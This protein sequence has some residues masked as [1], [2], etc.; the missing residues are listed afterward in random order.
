MFVNVKANVRLIVLLGQENDNFYNGRNTFTCNRY[1]YSQ[2]CDDE[3]QREKDKTKKFRTQYA[4]PLKN[5]HRC[6]S[7][8][9][10][11][12]FTGFSSI[13]NDEI[14]LLLKPSATILLN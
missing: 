4:I 2:V 13:C 1:I 9:G 8:N 14:Q 5:T 3:V 12:D 11:K 6:G 10:K 7:F